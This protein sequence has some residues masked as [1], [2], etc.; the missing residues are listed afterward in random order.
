MKIIYDTDQPQ[1]KRIELINDSGESY[2]GFHCYQIKLDDG[3]EEAVIGLWGDRKKRRSI[4][5][6]FKGGAT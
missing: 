6:K 4:L 5:E 1:E 2:Y 3:N